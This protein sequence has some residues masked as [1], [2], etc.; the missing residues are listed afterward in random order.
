MATP[1]LIAYHRASLEPA[2]RRSPYAPWKPALEVVATLLLFV[3]LQ[4]VFV[5]LFFLAGL[6]SGLGRDFFENLL[7][8]P[9]SAGGPMAM[10]FQYGAIALTSLA[11]F[12]G[13][14]LAGRKASALLSVAGRIRPRVLGL[15]VCWIGLPVAACLALDGLINGVPAPL[16]RTFWLSVVALITL[17]PLQ[18]AA[19]ELIF[20]GSLPQAVGAWVRSPAAAFGIV[21]PVFIVGH[22]YDA[23]GSLS[24]AVFAVMAS[25]LVYRTGGLEAAIVLHCANNMALSWADISGIQALPGDSNRF[26]IVAATFF[27]QYSGALIVLVVLRDY[28]PAAVPRRPGWFPGAGWYRGWPVVVRRGVA[29]QQARRVPAPRSARGTVTQT[30]FH[31]AVRPWWTALIEAGALALLFFGISAAALMLI[32]AIGIGAGLSPELIDLPVGDL[33]ANVALLITVAM[34]CV[35]PLLAARVVGRNPMRLISLAGRFRWRIA[36]I[37]AAASTAVYAAAYV[38][39]LLLDGAPDYSLSPKGAAFI[40]VC[41]LVIP[42][43]ALAEELVFR[44]SLP[45][46]VGTWVRSPLIAYGVSVPLFAAGHAYNWIGLT[47]IVVFAICAAAL[48]WYT[49]GIEAATA[50]HAVGNIVAFSGLGLGLEDPTSFEVAPATA[51]FSIATTLVAVGVTVWALHRWGEEGRAQSASPRSAAIL[52]TDRVNKAEGSVNVSA[53]K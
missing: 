33:D 18:C 53:P 35:A 43:Q 41:V 49:K 44:A 16:D 28:A 7:F 22:A 51:A 5:V 26:L 27:L 37:A 47:D 15:A 14:W 17:V 19:E 39:G 34:T 1:T 2:L 21:V 6:G 10:L 32:A 48:T 12:A 50:L 38:G 25:I 46:I 40:L 31:R 52:P 42:F 9:S 29:R 20:R 8:G 13:A 24:V 36:L 4:V 11:A 3:L 23:A 30:D 45:Q